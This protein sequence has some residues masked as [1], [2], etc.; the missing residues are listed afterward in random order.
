LE[1]ATRD[2]VFLRVTRTIGVGGDLCSRKL[3][4]KF[5][6]PYQ[7]LRRIGLVAYEIALPP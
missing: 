6:G 1:F 5:L 4:P 3:S 2:H 7:I